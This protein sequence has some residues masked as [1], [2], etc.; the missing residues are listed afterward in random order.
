[1]HSDAQPTGP[2]EADGQVVDQLRSAA[3]AAITTLDRDGPADP[4]P[5]T[6]ELTA[7]DLARLFCLGMG[8]RDNVARS[9]DDVAVTV[10]LTSGPPARRT[11]RARW[12]AHELTRLGHAELAAQFT[13]LATDPSL[14]T[15]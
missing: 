11:A 2:A 13:E 7:Y 8:D 6:C 1:M 3:L 15:P 14:Q 5:H 9:L 10:R 12:V 4:N